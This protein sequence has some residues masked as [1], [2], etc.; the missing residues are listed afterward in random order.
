MDLGPN[1]FKFRG[2]KIQPDPVHDYPTSLQ[3]THTPLVIDNGSYHCRVGWATDEKP[4][5]IFKNVVARQRGKKETDLQIGND[6]NN[7]EVVRWLL[8]T[9]FDKNVVTQ[10]D[11]Q[12]QIFDHIFQKLGINSEG[13]IQH[14]M[15]LTEP[16]LN[17]NYCRQQMSELLFECYHVPQI[18][19]GVDAMFSFYN[20]YEN[21]GEMDGLV[22]SCG[23]HAT[24]LLPVL[25]GRLDPTHARRISLG[26]SHLDLFMQKLLQ[27]KYP[28]HLNALTLSRA[29]ELIQD[30]CYTGV[31][32]VSE[33]NAWAD[34][35]YYEANVK[36]IQLPFTPLP[37]AS[38]SSEQQ[39]EKKDQQIRRL[40]EVNAKKRE[41]RLA[42]QQEKLQELLS[43]QEL[44]EEDRIEEFQKALKQLEFSSAEELQAAIDKLSTSIQKIKAK[45]LGIDVVE[46]EKEERE[47]VFDLLD[48]PDEDLLPAQQEIKK[49]QRI[50]KC[51]YEGR[52]RARKQR[53]EVKQKELEEER[54]MQ[55]KREQDYKGWLRE[56][57]QKRKLLMEK[58][59]KRRQRR[60]DMAKRRTLASQERMKI[61][62]QL[63]K[64]DS[65][66]DTDNF[67]QNDEDWNVYKQINIQDGD[68]DSDAD[69]DKLEQLE[70][71]L[72]EHDPE[73][74]KEA[75]GVNQGGI[76]DLAEYYRL[77]LA[78]EMIRVPEL[79]FQPS[80]IGFDQAGLTETIQFAM[81]KFSDDEQNRMAQN[82]FLTGSP[83]SF[84]KFKERMEVELRAIRPFQSLFNVNTAKNP[85][86]DAWYGEKKFATSP[87]FKSHSI[88][89]SEYEEKGGEYLKEH[90]ASNRYL[91]QPKQS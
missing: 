83:A 70:G 2:I 7:I 29:E 36:K 63:A 56:I 26:G 21:S 40:K 60:S 58:R 22:L 25:N 30:Y 67:G 87:D 80:M 19:Y 68:S 64:R 84:P 61:I 85:T 31:D 14:P 3:E 37:G 42:E 53:E 65:K 77:H 35:D 54:R 28:G 91:P 23:N 51:A 8:K 47:P 12:E 88:T 89:R 45:I 20:N 90:E 50:L 33:V 46:E 15:V 32:F 57:R 38:L 11:V 1:I 48:I 43:L 73:F 81:K 4:R 74:E 49:R 75:N 71:F 41:E 76:V 5:M 82:V 72:R 6:I 24:H 34:V 62:S 17:P 55:M 18:A 39:K 13:G 69:Q 52:V 78:I 9:Q 59:N 27:L 10:Y 86:L 66:K 44:I 16:P 79:L